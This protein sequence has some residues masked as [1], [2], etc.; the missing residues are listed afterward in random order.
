MNNADRNSDLDS[1]YAEMGDVKPIGGDDKVSLH[2][3]TAKLA[4]KSKRAALMASISKKKYNPLSM[5]GVV[6]VQPDD[7]MTYQKPGIQDGVYKNLRQGK[8]DIEFRLSLKGL[9]VEQSRDAFYD[10]IAKCHARGV[11][12]LLVQHGRGYDSKPYPGLKK[13]YVKHWLLQLHEVIAFHSAQPHH[14]G[15]GATYV[16]LKKHPEQKLINREKNRRG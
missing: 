7:F 3:P 1:F 12:M 2:N 4:E 9:T 14:G 15:L 16:L 10:S 5:E 8:Y 6:P 13:S 11:R